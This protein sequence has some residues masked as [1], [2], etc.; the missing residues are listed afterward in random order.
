MQP[1]QLKL[2]NNGIVSGMHSIPLPPSI[3]SFHR[4]LV[5]GL[6]GG[7]YNSQYFD[8]TPKTSAS[9]MSTSLGV[10][11]VSIDRPSYGGTSSILPIPE[12]SDFNRETGI[13]LHY[14]IL[15]K[16][17][18]EF[19]QPNRCNSI[20][21]LCH[22][23]GVMGGIVAASLH[24]QDKEP[25]YPLGGLIANGMGH[26]Q[27]SSMKENPPTFQPMDD[28][29]ALLPLEAK[30]SIMFKPGT[31]D[32]EVLEQTE[33]LNSPIPIAEVALFA[34]VWLPVWKTKWAAH[35][36]VPVMFSLVDNDPFFTTNEEDLEGCVKAFEKSVR[37]D[38]S[39]VK[40]APHCIELSRWSYGWYARCF[41]FALECA[42][43]MAVANT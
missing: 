36:S 24:A 4:P 1:F 7:C 32:S 26:I 28:N 13:Y 33:R 35:I 30:D 18:S 17:W 34:K 38:R 42:A 23:F 3:S 22:S 5:V 43:N 11:F 39:L 15:P 27:S 2:A 12:G 6:H 40:E 31:V 19:G 25:L 8:A 9:T 10:P 29:Y 41:G 14:H 37:V 20:V 21:L 16:L